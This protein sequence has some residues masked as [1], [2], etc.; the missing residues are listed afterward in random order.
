MDVKQEIDLV[1][2]KDILDSLK[3]ASQNYAVGARNTIQLKDEE[4]KE[5]LKNGLGQTGFEEHNTLVI[6]RRNETRRI[7]GVKIF[8]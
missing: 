4:I 7:E 6:T 1:K 8:K 2:L 3:I 5:A